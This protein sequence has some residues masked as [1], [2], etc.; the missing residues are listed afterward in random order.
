MIGYV[1][2]ATAENV[3]AQAGSG[4][5]VRTYLKVTREKRLEAWLKL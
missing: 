3:S 2:P 4:K 5:K 1:I